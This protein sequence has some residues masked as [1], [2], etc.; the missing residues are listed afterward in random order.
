MKYQIHHAVVIGAGT[1]GAAI[2]AHLA[3][4]GIPVTLLD[5]VPDK[6][7]PEEQK[8]GL[9]LSDPQVRNRIVN[10]GLERA[11]KSRPAS[12]M[13]ADSAALVRTGNIEDDFTALSQADWVIEVIVED[14]AAKRALMQRIDAARPEHTIISTNT[15]G[16]PINSIAAGF[17]EG[18]RQHFLG[19]HFF[20]PPR[21]LKLLEVIPT[22]DTLPDVVRDISHFAEYRLGKGVVICKDTPNFIANRLGF[23]GGAFALD[24]ILEN[25]YSVEEVDAITGPVIGRPKT[26]TFR[27]VDLV[28]VDVWEHV[29]HN[30]APAVPQDVMAQR[31][32]GSQRTNALIHEMVTRGW[33]GNKTKQGFYKETRTPEGG[34]EFFPLNL[35]TL[36]YEPPVKPKYASIG[37]VKDIESLGERLKTLMA[38]NDRAGQLVQALTYQGLAYAC[39]CIPE[40]A[41]T[42]RPIDD[43]MRWGFGHEAGPFETWDMLGVK[44]TAIC[45]REAGFPTAPWVDEMLSAGCPTFYQYDGDRKV[46]VYNPGLQDYQIIAQDPAVIIL[47]EEKAVGKTMAE[48]PGAS[49]IDLGDGVLNVEFHT[50]M[51]ILDDD[52]FNMIETGLNQVEVDY[53]GLVIGNNAENFSAGA[54]LFLVVMAAQGGMWDQLEAVVN[55]MQSLN[56]RMRYFPKPV[57][58]APV[59][60]NLGGGAEIMTHANRVVAAS[61]LYTGFVEIG[62]GVIPAGGGT[63][64]MLRRVL[65]PPMRTQTADAL[66]FLQ[67][68][69]EQIGTAQVSTSAEEARQMG[70]LSPSDRIVMNRDFLLAEAKREILHLAASGYRQ[71][72]PEKIYAAGGDALAALRVGIFMYKESGT[73]TE[74]EAFIGN[75]LAYVMTGGELSHPTWVDEQYI[76]DLEREAFLSLCGQEKTQQRMWNILQGGKRLRN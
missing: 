65:N 73:I 51:N 12:F 60:M 28:G 71:P 59:G 50:K 41:D 39:A 5:I 19:T 66:P 49:L 2:A 22:T 23:G 70:L 33:L 68:I 4:A 75:K 54:N 13:S 47:K 15:S 16:I 55:R 74:Y 45:I 38:A 72:A 44:E 67:R 31:Y 18:L 26:A 48:N 9:A 36:E 6:L 64:E 29:G 42:P 1:M 20:N 11:L 34:K 17:S 35:K 21:Y 7:T 63:K 25:D 62:P 24:Y 8:K 58:A 46:G 27:L 76:L 52:V 57:I 3:N 32:L 10:Q 37:K 14:L 43:A 56:M 61:E 30:L 40:I 53:E 69:F